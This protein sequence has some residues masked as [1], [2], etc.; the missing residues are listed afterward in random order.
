MG[1]RTRQ[2]KIVT[3]KFLAQGTIS[4]FKMLRCVAPLTFVFVCTL[5]PIDACMGGSSSQTAQS[6]QAGFQNRQ[7]GLDPRISSVAFVTVS[8]GGR[9]ETEDII[10]GLY[11]NVVPRTA[12]NFYEVC[13]GDNQGLSLVGSP[14]HRVIPNFMIQGGDFTRGDGRGGKSIYGNKFEDENFQLTHTGPGILSMANSGKDTNGSQFFITVAKTAWLDGKHVVFGKVSRGMDVVNN[15]VN[16]DRNASDK[17][18]LPIKISSCSGT[19]V[20]N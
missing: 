10:I 7:G 5:L 12:R 16:Q 11:G 1:T 19:I 4:K 15:V 20:A 9:D 2:V 8:I 13:R 6:K 17:P 14:F 18:N 3:E